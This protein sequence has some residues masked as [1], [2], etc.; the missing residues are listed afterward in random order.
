MKLVNYTYENPEALEKF[1][2]TYFRAQDHLFIQLFCG[3]VDREKILHIVMAL[4][5]ICPKSVI[6]GTSTAGE[7]RSGRIKTGTI[8]ISFCL[9]QKSLAKAY[10]FPEVNFHSGKCAAETIVE[11]NTQVCIALAHPFGKDDSEDFIAGFNSINPSIPLAGGNAA[12]AF[13]FQSAFIIH[14]TSIFDSGIVIVTL[15]GKSLYV[16]TAYSL[17]W[18]QVG[19][20]MCITK[21]HKGTVYEVDHQSVQELFRH[22]LGNDVVQNLPSSAM[23]FPFVKNSD[24][25]EV[26]RSLLGVNDDGS[27][28]FS[29]YLEE[30][31][32]VRFAIGNVENV[33]DKAFLMQAKIN[34]KPAEAIFIYSCSVRK[35]FLD[36]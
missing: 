20:E 16:N 34:E 35:L 33:M 4:K 19:R 14:D 13:V 17:G 18:A 28:E 15:N 12:D 1:V 3:D 29:G 22:Y 25:I 6:I 32:K 5:K 9:L 11:P 7:I 10:Y 21:A 23:E 27:L 30:G 31:D 24:G 8:Q 36:K 2:Y 26:C